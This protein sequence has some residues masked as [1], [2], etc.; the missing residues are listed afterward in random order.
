[1]VLGAHG[2]RRRRVGPRPPAASYP[3]RAP[4]TGSWLAPEVRTLL[5]LALGQGWDQSLAQGA[6]A[7]LAGVSDR[8]LWD[9]RLALKRRLLAEVARRLEARWS[10]ARAPTR[11]LGRAL[12]PLTTDEALVVVFA[13]PLAPYNRTG[14]LFE[15]LDRLDAW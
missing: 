6:V 11:P 3:P 14:P 15:D 10:E 9:V 13:R 1:V 12:A 4:L 5:D 2:G 7:D 8:S